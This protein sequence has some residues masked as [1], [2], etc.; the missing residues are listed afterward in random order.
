MRGRRG[1]ESSLS[2][3]AP[4]LQRP[5]SSYP[6]PATRLQLPASP[7]AEVE[8]G[9][10][11]VG[12]RGAAHPQPR[13][14]ALGTCPGRVTDTSCSQP[15]A[16]LAAALAPLPLAAVRREQLRRHGRRAYP[17][18]LLRSRCCWRERCT[19]RR[20]GRAL[21]ASVEEGS[22]VVP[23]AS[24]GAGGGERQRRTS[25]LSHPVQRR[26]KPLGVRALV[27][28]VRSPRRRLE[29]RRQ[30]RPPPAAPL[31]L[32][33]DAHGAEAPAWRGRDWRRRV[34]VVGKQEPVR[35]RRLSR[36]PTK[37]GAEDVSRET[38][39]HRD[40]RR[41]GR[42]RSWRQ[43]WREDERLVREH[44]GGVVGHAARPAGAGDSHA[45]HSGPHLRL[46]RRPRRVRAG[47]ATLLAQAQHGA[48]QRRV[49]AN[50]PHN[51]VCTALSG[52]LPV[53]AG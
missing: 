3:P 44:R 4:R 7:P 1:A 33:L 43:V 36:P 47:A 34:E 39:R 45:I 14:A 5:A 18:G 49:G 37:R 51:N 23:A 32:D 8:Q 48:R 20:A 13:V 24:F 53:G 50:V 31:G 11:C 9:R 19:A 2:P 16:S 35:R 12:R 46:E 21:A 6:P 38:R 15:A 28:R 26:A 22:R 40:E 29:E 17:A 25:R 30:V 41:A 10:L 27:A 42:D 52:R